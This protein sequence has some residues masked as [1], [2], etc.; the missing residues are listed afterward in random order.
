MY[1]WSRPD[2][3]HFQYDLK[4]LAHP[5]GKAASL[6]G[7][8]LGRMTD[9]GF[10]LRGL[11]SLGALTLDVVRTSAIEGDTLDVNTVRSSIA[12]RLNID[13]GALAPSDRHVD[14][15]VAMV[16]DA[17]SEPSRALT[18]D[19]LLSWQASLFPT[20][21]SDLSSIRVGA[22]RDDASGPMQVVSGPASNP[23]LPQRKVHFEAPPAAQL[24]AEVTRFLHWFNDD[25]TDAPLIKAGIAHF[26][27]VT[28]HPFEDGNGRVARAVGDLLLARADQSAQ[29]FYSL[30]AQIQLERKRYYDILESSQKGSLD[31]TAW[32]LWFLEAL[33]RALEHAD[34]QLESVLAKSRFWQQWAGTRFNARQNKVLNRLL[35]GFEGKLTSSKWAALA[36]C[37]PDTALRD[38]S[39]LVERGVLFRN[40]A[41]GRSTSYGVM[42]GDETR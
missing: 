18:Q 1:I 40:E 33:V 19:R 13:I 11:A 4:A 35:D 36:K 31:I 25:T 17:T 10:D 23:P 9:I 14:G 32:L 15:V 12:Q 21:R 38:I 6:Q 16:I 7:R 37:S 30:S 29:R 5:L 42:P 20:G 2:W 27:L 41:G 8:L 3:P 22:L 39:D 26:W 28:L 34:T 24:E